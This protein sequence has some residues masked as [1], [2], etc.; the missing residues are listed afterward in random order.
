MESAH[1]N[2]ALAAT[3]LLCWAAVTLVAIMVLFAGFR[4]RS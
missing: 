2:Q 4:K 3:F 1:G